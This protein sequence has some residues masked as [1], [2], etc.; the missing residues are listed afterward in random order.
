MAGVYRGN[1]DGFRYSKPLESLTK[2]ELL[3]LAK[4]KKIEADDKLT[5]KQIIDKLEEA[6]GK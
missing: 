2:K 1:D 6:E 4:D 3:N 5:K